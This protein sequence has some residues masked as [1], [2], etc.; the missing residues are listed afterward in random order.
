[1]P[2]ALGSPLAMYS[3]STVQNH[4][5][6]F[7]HIVNAYEKWLTTLRHDLFWKYLFSSYEM[8]DSCLS[9]F[10]SILCCKFIARPLV[11]TQSPFAHTCTYVG[12]YVYLNVSDGVDR[13]FCA[14]L[15][16]FCDSVH[17]VLEEGFDNNRY[18]IMTAMI[19]KFYY[20]QKHK[21]NIII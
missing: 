13:D 1:M 8:M 12:M 9:Y 10:R 21:K 4:I 15:P 6:R 14:W 2:L 3:V 20:N 17:T 5:V 7:V 18:G 19:L 11:V 16:I